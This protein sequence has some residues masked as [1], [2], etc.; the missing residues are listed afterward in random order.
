MTRKTLEQIESLAFKALVA[1]GAS[2][3]NA[4][5]VARSVRRA[6]ADAIGA[7]GLG[8]LPI[9]LSHLRSGKVDGRAIPVVSRPRAG[10]VVAEA[11]HGFAHP[12]Y[13]AALPHLVAGARESGC[14][15][16]AISRSYSIGVL[17][18]PVEDL[19]LCGLIGL[20]FTNSPPNMAPWGGTQRLFGTNPL[21]FAAPRQDRPPLVIDQAT[22]AVTKVALTAAAKSGQPIPEGWALDRHGRPTQDA[23][24]ALAGSIAPF[25]GAKGAG[26]A[27]IV[28]ILA[29]ALTGANFSKD[30]SPYASTDG[31]PPGVGQCF[32]AIDPDAFAPGFADR[33]EQLITA[34]LLQDGVRLPGDRRLAAR[35]RAQTEGV[36]VDDALLAEIERL[37][38]AP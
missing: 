12:A 8:Y 3:A 10:T 31:P 25:G 22:S 35:E 7:V 26:M 36:D 28:E 29:A 11:G 19:A 24:A 6:E 16:L 37:A 18:H 30:A 38:E 34:M 21:A 2:P 27:L 13:D 9:Y 33:M 32:I 1:C 5:P 23:Q 14:A 4:G 15:C 20:A 17:G